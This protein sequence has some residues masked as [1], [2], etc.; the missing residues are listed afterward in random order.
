[1]ISIWEHETFFAPVD[2]AIVGGGF[3]GLWT[4]LEI[5]TRNP[6]AKI[7]I[8][9]KGVT[10]MGASTRNAGFAC[11]GSPTEMIADASNMGED[12]MWNIV[13]MRYKGIKK[14][15]QHFKD[16]EIGFDHCGGYECFEEG[17]L[18]INEI[19]HKLQWLNN[20]MEKITGL[21]QTFKW[22]NEKLHRFKL[23]G[24]GALIE[25]E[26]EGGIHSGKLL[27][28]LCKKVQAL[29]VNILTAVEVKGWQTLNNYIEVNTAVA[30]L[31]TSQLIVCAN[32]LSST[33]IPGFC[34]EPARGQVLVT[35]PIK[36]LR[37]KGTFHFD[38]G[39]YYF[40][41]IENRILIGGARNKDFANERTHELQLNDYL[42]NELEQFLA[43]HLLA[44]HSF[45]IDYRWSGIM[46]FT[47]NKMPLVK[48]LDE[49]I[50]AGVCCNGMGVALSP[51]IAE[52]LAAS[53]LPQKLISQM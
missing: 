40:R 7:T 19:D 45:N 22:S 46:G 20:G 1:M 48:Q 47:E 49:T 21:S 37:M 51:V 12:N 18:S 30:V 53:L 9:E 5:I 15:R 6:K 4:A 8:V 14:V 43:S 24:F 2:V 35:E 38:E 29:G 11:F 28:A 3:L 41:N 50:F 34:V 39:Y 44:N 52:K 23:S 16:S 33:L 36:D 10:P 13:E 17:T 42:Q 32:A 26:I 25:N 27:Q 31:K